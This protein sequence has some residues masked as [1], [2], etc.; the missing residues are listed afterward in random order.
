MGPK[1]K[2]RITWSFKRC[3]EGFMSGDLTIFSL[4]FK[5]HMRRGSMSPDEFSMYIDSYT[6]LSWSHE[7]P[8]IQTK[9]IPIYLTPY[10]MRNAL[11]QNE[12]G[13]EHPARRE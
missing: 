5:V 1:T 12:S 9:A 7:K 10:S 8:A 6:R 3:M 13:G 11:I 4:A 2:R